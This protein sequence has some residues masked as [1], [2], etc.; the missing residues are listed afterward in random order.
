MK[1]HL[2]RPESVTPIAPY[3]ARRAELPDSVE[4]QLEF[5]VALLYREREYR[6]MYS[7]AWRSGARPAPVP[8]GPF[9]PYDITADAAA[10][11]TALLDDPSLLNAS[12]PPEDLFGLKRLAI[13]GLRR[14][15]RPRT[16]D[17]FGWLVLA[18]LHWQLC[19]YAAAETANDRASDLG[20]SD[21]DFTGRIQRRA[22]KLRAKVEGDAFT[23]FLTTEKAFCERERE[24]AMAG[25]DETKVPAALRELIPLARQIG[26]GD[27]ACR[28]F[29][30]QKMPARERRAAAALIARHADEIDA[31]LATQETSDVNESAAFFWLRAVGEELG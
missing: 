12:Q 2:L 14:T 9:V 1:I 16:P 21:T 5:A 11:I 22:W 23:R 25:F 18:H 6:A 3:L 31:W 24:A 15:L 30:V 8:D 17:A 10:S 28:G 26:V 7:V 29:F 19:E 13:D 27:D 20:A 4:R